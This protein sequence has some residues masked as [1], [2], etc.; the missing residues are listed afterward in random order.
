M[1]GAKDNGAGGTKNTAPER[2]TPGN[3][4][5]FELYAAMTRGPKRVALR[6]FGKKYTYENVFEQSLDYAN[7]IAQRCAGTGQRIAILMP[8][9][10]QFV[11]AY[12][13]TLM[14]GNVAAPL[15]FTSLIPALRN[16]NKRLQMTEDM[17]EELRIA[18][19]PV[20][21]MARMFLPLV[22][23]FD[24][25]FC[26]K[27]RCILHTGFE[28]AFNAFSLRRLLFSLRARKTGETGYTPDLFRQNTSALPQY[29]SYTPPEIRNRYDIM[30]AHMSAPEDRD[31][32]IIFTGGTTGTPKGAVHTHRSILA[33]VSQ[34]REHFGETLFPKNV[35]TLA[36][37]PW[38]HVFGLL[39]S[40]HAPL[41]ASDG[42]VTIMPSFS[43]KE[44]LSRIERD[45]IQVFCGVNRMYEAM[46]K[47][48]EQLE[49][50]YY[51]THYDFSDLTFCVS[52]AG[53]ISTELCQ[54]FIALTG[55]S[56]FNGYG[57]TECPIIAATR[58]D[59]TANTA[60]VGMG[61][62]RTDICIR[63]TE[64]GEP[65]PDGETGEITVRG[66]Q[67]MSRYIGNDAETARTLIDGWY[68]TGDI[69]RILP[70]G[71]I[72]LTGRLK[73][74][75]TINGENYYPEPVEIALGLYEDIKHCAIF[76][77]PDQT[78]GEAFVVLAV[79]NGKYE[80]LVRQV[81]HEF[82]RARIPTKAIKQITLVDAQTFL[83]FINPIGKVLRHKMKNFYLATQEHAAVQ[84]RGQHITKEL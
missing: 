42:T 43:A 33:S 75:V 66:P 10:P 27:D 53:P 30:R 39:S 63:S 76:G 69:G 7:I 54:K 50:P 55:V 78:G 60:L 12:F 47:E 32:L 84:K 22:D 36:A 67:L 9:M 81:H 68:Y 4:L 46:V 49:N 56:L 77:I 13:G 72:E 61:V 25:S 58:D 40:L 35:R 52:G 74:M 31:A 80:D 15:N 28:Q 38:F 3:T 11:F 83:R 23:Q 57:S 70:T 65:I 17:H 5:Q 79:T 29:G 59:A 73:N 20:I 14:S 26:A 51:H 6:F 41:L 18:D 34:I 64:T 37:L 24:R 45:K 19:P 2:T 62:P 21:I 48:I 71:A 44:A 8:N 82:A 1:P 16:P